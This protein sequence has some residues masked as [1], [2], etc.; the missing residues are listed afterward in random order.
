MKPSLECLGHRV[1]K[2]G[3][4]P[5]EAKVQAIKD[6]PAPTNV[7]E[8]KSFLGMINFYGKFL[9]NLSSLLEPLHEL[10]RKDNRWKWRKRKQEAL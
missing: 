4:H 1:D 6:A 8:L 2:E 10:L 7:T 5:V 9:P 3:F